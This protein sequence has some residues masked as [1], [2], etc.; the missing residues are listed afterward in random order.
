MQ[1][2]NKSIIVVSECNLLRIEAIDVQ[3]SHLLDYRALPRFASP[4]KQEEDQECQDWEN[5]KLRSRR[6]VCHVRWGWKGT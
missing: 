5:V 1:A 3:Y 2:G 6:L 4:W